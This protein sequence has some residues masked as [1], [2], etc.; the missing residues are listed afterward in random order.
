[1]L[2]HQRFF[3]QEWSY[4]DKLVYRALCAEYGLSQPKN[5]W[6]IQDK[7]NENDRAK[8]LWD[9]YMYT[10]K[11]ILANQR[12]IVAV[13]KE[14]QRAILTDIAVPGDYNIASKEKKKVEKY[15]PLRKE[16]EKRW[17]VNTTVIPI[18]LGEEHWVP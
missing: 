14:N 16:I 10:D 3:L 1:M 17:K 7:V 2:T 15:Q 11:Q 13:D 18:V 8:I 5:W 4:D 9:F 6:K 12:D